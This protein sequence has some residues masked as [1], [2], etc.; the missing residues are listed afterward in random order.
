[1]VAPLFLNAYSPATA[2]FSA[3]LAVALIVKAAP[4]ATVMFLA[5]AATPAGITGSLAT[6]GMVTTSAASGMPA[7]QLAGTFQAVLDDP[8]Q[9]V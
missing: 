9:V 1:M 2:P 5:T 7:D 6:F 8:S 4:E 3:R